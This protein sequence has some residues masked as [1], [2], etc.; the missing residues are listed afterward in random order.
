[1]AQIQGSVWTSIC[2]CG[3]YKS[4]SMHFYFLLQHEFCFLILLKLEGI[5]RKMGNRRNNL[6]KRAN[7]YGITVY[8]GKNTVYTI[9]TSLKINIWRNHLYLSAQPEAAFFLF[10]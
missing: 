8:N 2:L 9:L 4:V 6:L 7:I 5:A 1:M 3:L 10:L